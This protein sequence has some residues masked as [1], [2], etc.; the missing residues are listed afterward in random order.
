MCYEQADGNL[1]L[2]LRVAW[3]LSRHGREALRLPVLPEVR[4]IW[5]A[6]VGAV[7]RHAN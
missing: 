4:R 3:D 7:D 5:R 6:G 2:L 1:D